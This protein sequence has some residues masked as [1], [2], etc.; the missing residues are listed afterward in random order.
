MR[1]QVVDHHC[2]ACGRAPQDHLA[3]LQVRDG[4][5]RAFDQR[6][7]L[8]QDFTDLLLGGLQ[9]AVAFGIERANLFDAGGIDLHRDM[10]R[11]HDVQRVVFERVRCGGRRM[12]GLGDDQAAELAIVFRFTDDEAGL[13][14]VAGS[15]A[16]DDVFVHCV[17][18]VIGPLARPQCG[19]GV[20]DLAGAAERFDGRD[21]RNDR[22]GR[23]FRRR[24]AAAREA[25]WRLRQSR[26][27][28][29]EKGHHGQ[30]S[31][32]ISCDCLHGLLSPKFPREML[33]RNRPGCYSDQRGSMR[34]RITFTG[35]LP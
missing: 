4:A 29:G 6:A 33:L 13:V 22:G 34:S 9:R 2:R 25:G 16:G 17:V 20:V 35:A 11:I 24:G 26:A 3:Q 32:K 10:A 23:R 28:H 21:R 1:R 30:R 18:E 5:L 19:G 12:H 31:P 7:S 15:G 27:R 14:G 8:G